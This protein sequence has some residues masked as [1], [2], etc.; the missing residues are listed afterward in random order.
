MQN[1]ATDGLY[2]KEFIARLIRAA[3]STYLLFRPDL[4]LQYV[5]NHYLISVTVEGLGLAPRAITHVFL[6]PSNCP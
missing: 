1:H 2:L 4:Y 5:V 6:D 3:S